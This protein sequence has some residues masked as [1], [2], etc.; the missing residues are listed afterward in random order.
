MTYGS[1]LQT[2][3]PYAGLSGLGLDMQSILE[4]GANLLPDGVQAAGQ[5]VIDNFKKPAEEVIRSVAGERVLEAVQAGA[6]QGID[7]VR[8]GAGLPPTT[9]GSASPPPTAQS[10][11]TKK[12]GAESSSAAVSAAARVMTPWGIGAAVVGGGITYAVTGRMKRPP[13][14]GRRIA[15]SALVGVAAGIVTGMATAK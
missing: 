9:S 5:D 12:A 6:Q 10:S 15:A 14:R 4:T 8:Q 7:A 2:T 3:V 1:T 13:K 11:E